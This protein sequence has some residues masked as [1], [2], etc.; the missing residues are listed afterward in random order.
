MR[1]PFIFFCN[2]LLALA[3][4]AQQKHYQF[5]ESPRTVKSIPTNW[6]F[7]YFPDP[8]G[9]K[10][11]CEAVLFDDSKWPVICLPHTWQT[12]ETTRELHPYIRSA[13][14]DDDPYWW[15]GWGWY[16]KHITIGNQFAKKRV[17]LE[18]DGV[19]KYARIFLNGKY[20]EEHKGGYTSFYV[21]ITD[22]VKFGEDNLL[23]VAVQNSLK[24]RFSIP[25]MNAGNFDVYGGIHRTVRLVIKEQVNIPFQ[26]SYKH[27]GGCF[28]TTPAVSEK[29]ATVRVRTFVQNNSKMTQKVQLL[30]WIT[31]SSNCVVGKLDTS[32][33][34]PANRLTEFNQLSER[35]G[36]PHLW[37]PETP[38]LYN[39]FSEVYTDG[40]LMDSFTSTFGIRSVAWNFETHRLILNGKSTNLHGINRH[41]EYVWLGA[42]F[43]EW[44]ALRDMND[45]R[46]GLEAN[47]M[48]TAHYP[49]APYIYN[50]TDR[51]GICINEELPNIKK[52][53]FNDLVQEQ[54]CR[55][56]IRRDRNHPSILFWSMG[57]E[58][59]DACDSRFAMEEDTT[60]ILTVR[61]PYNDSYN[62]KYVRHTDKE[63]PLESF[64]RCTIKGWY[65]TDDKN[66]QP[67]DNQWAG[68]EEWQHTQSNKSVISEHNGAVWLYADHGADRE[69]VN[70]PLK[71]INP[72]GWVDSWRN[73]K[74]AYYQRQANFAKRPMV[75]VHPHF[76]R[77]TYLGQKKNFIVDS[78]AREVEL[79]VNGKSMGILKPSKSNNFCV[80]FENVLVTEGEIEAIATASDGCK[81]SHKTVMSGKPA[82]LTITP[83]AKSMRASADNVVELK[84]DI[85]DAKGIH[86][87]GAGNVLKFEV[88]GPA[89]LVGPGMYRS[90]RDKNEEYEGT[91]YIDAPVTNLIR[92]TGKAGTVT[93]KVSST[94]LKSA[95]AVVA[96]NAAPDHDPIKGITEPLL[97]SEGR[98][99]VAI[100][101]KKANFIKAPAEMKEYAGELRFPVDKKN[102]YPQLMQAFVQKENPS[103][104]TQST[105]FKLSIEALVAILT[106]TGSYNN[107]F[108]YIVA[109]DYNY[110]VTQYNLSRAISRQIEGRNFP[111]AYREELSSYYAGQI[112]SQGRNKNLAN[113]TLSIS[114]IPLGGRV[115][116]IGT[117]KIFKEAIHDSETDLMV[118][119][120]KIYPSV[121]N[122]SKEELKKALGLVLR[123]NPGVSFKSVRDKK[124]KER[125]DSYAIEPGRAI[126]IPEERQLLTTNFP[127]TKL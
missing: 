18:F 59:T 17:C 99:P 41:E 25:P 84:V 53:E 62:P 82:A 91:M 47:F 5:P 110:I 19:Q 23:T 107:L 48:R 83:T 118:L 94:G 97:D 87:V 76:W 33:L 103:I 28:I 3:L 80:C 55:E 14:Q 74:Y 64:L 85:V 52:Q 2:L 54:N 42:A 21:D 40:K 90:D 57:N 105:E 126:L 9:D 116:V 56:M 75:F 1:L 73:P 100:N 51:H 32:I 10:K 24:D 72:K 69:Y 61:Q 101:L 11:G 112:I 123:I 7:N 114:K 35:I 95:S 36:N 67:D 117:Q 8:E 12:F 27:E 22:A 121:K 98:E 79:L 119:L 71:H 104:N 65:D 34:I 58:T 127:D 106:S 45:I 26:G 20:L 6:T 109:D 15:N 16:R 108:G 30:T 60:R 92:A 49:Q 78:N 86:V 89:R 113:E 115:Y 93:V 44:V 29:E 120:Q 77:S 37:S 63:M 66:L 88:E 13:S 46:Y 125:T 122:Y 70:S 38:Y 81:V 4:Q 96:V 68:T 111:E 31:D 124:T 102:E 50:F 43:P 39:C